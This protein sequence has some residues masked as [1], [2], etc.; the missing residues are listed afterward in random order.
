MDQLNLGAHCIYPE[1]QYRARFWIFPKNTQ[2][3]LIMTVHSRGCVQTE[4]SGSESGLKC[5]KYGLPAV[6]GML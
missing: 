5:E 3:Y 4:L 1:Q 2:I 6:V